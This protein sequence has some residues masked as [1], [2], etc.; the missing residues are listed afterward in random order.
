MKNFTELLGQLK[1]DAL[2][3]FCDE[4]VFRIVVNIV[5]QKQYQ[6][7][8]LIPILGGFHTAKYLQHSIG[9]YIRGS[10]LEELFVKHAYLG[11]KLLILI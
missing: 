8:S 9:K 1:Q 3:L 5:L 2:P 11:L 10:E 7:R 6:F 4:G